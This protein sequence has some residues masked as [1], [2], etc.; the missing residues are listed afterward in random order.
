MQ[1]NHKFGYLVVFGSF[2]FML[3][4]FAVLYNFGVFFN[5]IQAEFGWS[6]GVISG[7][8]S[9]LVLVSGVI[10]IIAGRLADK[11][12]PF[13]LAVTITFSLGA[14]YILLSFT[15]TIIWFYIC[16]VAIV[17]LGVGSAM[18]SMLP[19]LGNYFYK[20][21]GLMIG[22]AASGIGVAALVLCPLTRKL[23]M[24]YGWRNAYLVL[25][26]T[27]FIIL[28]LACLIFRSV[29]NDQ[30]KAKAVSTSLDGITFNEALHDRNFYILCVLYFL[31]GYSLQAIM[32]HIIP[33]TTDL[34][35]TVFAVQMIAIIGA[36][37]ML[38]RVLGAWISDHLGVKC[39]FIIHF[40]LLCAAFIIILLP[41]SRSTLVVF[42]VLFG[43]AYGG[44][45]VLTTISVVDYFGKRSSGLLLGIILM[46][47]T[48]GGAIGPLVTGVL[49]D[50]KGNYKIAFIVC[51][52]MAV[53]TFVLSARLSKPQHGV[54]RQQSN[55]A[56]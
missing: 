12:G 38:T 6:R 33:Y 19:V 51:F 10:G 56:K 48:L 36:L 14:G 8:F 42:A 27:I 53:L 41:G 46:L 18:P 13:L 25:G 4:T 9:L 2:L 39:T 26:I 24:A 1:V 28:G 11:Y 37:N 47:N 7:A 50:I 55:I 16:H 22:L 23:I 45:M 29:T 20:N 52:I 35:Y 54:T 3:L 30:H 49:F 32:V 40:G 44:I 21:R 15:K 43:L 17:S 34:G 31:F 5:Y